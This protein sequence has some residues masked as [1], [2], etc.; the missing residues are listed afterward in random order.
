[1][2]IQARGQAFGEADRSTA[3][4]HSPL[5]SPAGRAGLSTR[6]RTATADTSS[7]LLPGERPESAFS[8]RL[9]AQA[10]LHGVRV[11][12]LQVSWGTAYV[13]GV[14]VVFV[15]ACTHQLVRLPPPSWA[16]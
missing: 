14:D 15:C 2:D 12:E 13:D 10:G 3:F 8:E 5:G 9:R 16:V 11:A 4:G 6:D 7:L 1:M